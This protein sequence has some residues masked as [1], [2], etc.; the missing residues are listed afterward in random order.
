M[1]RPAVILLLVVVNTS[2]GQQVIESGCSRVPVLVDE[3]QERMGESASH[4]AQSANENANTSMGA[5][6]DDRM[7]IQVEPRWM[8]G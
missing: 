6:G 8:M 2:N 3:E 1:T 7:S 5:D 4:D